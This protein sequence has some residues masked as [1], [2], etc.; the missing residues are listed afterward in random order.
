MLFS[1]IISQKGKW[2]S[3][4]PPYPHLKMFWEVCLSNK[5]WVLNGNGRGLHFTA[6]A[7]LIA[8]HVL[9]LAGMTAALWAAGS[10]TLSI[11]SAPMTWTP[12]PQ[13]A[14]TPTSLSLPGRARRWNG[15]SV[16]AGPASFCFCLFDWFS[17]GV[18]NWNQTEDLSLAR[19]A[20]PCWAV[21]PALLPVSSPRW[22][23]IRLNCSITP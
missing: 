5:W 22:C 6:Y 11:T 10:V 19:Q 1:D 12:R 17:C 2:I 21:S 9:C 23:C 18:V 4:F 15:L 16:S 8:L 13:S 3:L 14:L 7:W 20:L